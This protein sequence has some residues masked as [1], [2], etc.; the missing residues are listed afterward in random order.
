MSPDLPLVLHVD[1]DEDIREIALIALETIGGLTVVQCDSGAEAL[2][3]APQSMPDLFLLDVMMPGMTGIETLRGLRSM[4]Q[5]ADTPAIFMTAKIHDEDVNELM[6]TGAL[7]VIKKPFDTMTV[8][9]EIVTIWR[10][11]S[12]KT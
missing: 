8:A 2:R 10:K 4:E 5:F 6:A 11:A 12:L 3:L 7:A 1:D 9:E